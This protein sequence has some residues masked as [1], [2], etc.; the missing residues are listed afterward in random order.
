MKSIL[1]LLL[2]GLSS[3]S[4]LA[5]DTLVVNLGLGWNA[6]TPA[7]Y[8]AGSAAT[9]APQKPAANQPTLFLGLAGWSQPSESLALGMGIKTWVSGDF[10]ANHSQ[11]VIAMDLLKLGIKLHQAWWLEGHLGIAKSFENKIA[12]GKSGGLAIA[13]ALNPHNRWVLDGFWA[14]SDQEQNDGTANLIGG[15]MQIFSLYYQKTF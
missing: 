10:Y 8:V 2:L 4:V 13:Y 15:R 7:Y 12:T 14:D 3:A 6:S 5:Q 9:S 1:T 11:D